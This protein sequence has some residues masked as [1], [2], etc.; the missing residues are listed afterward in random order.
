MPT[1][2]VES[3]GAAAAVAE[4][5][6]RAEAAA[7]LGAGI[8]YIRTT[9]VPADQTLLHVFEASSPE[10][11]GEAVAG[12]ALECD[13]IVEVVET[14]GDSETPRRRAG[15]TVPSARWERGSER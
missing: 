13:R 8:S 7:R 3:Y 9:I 5:R 10:A 15:D 6:A 11:L 2:I 1:Y 4:Q 12:A 14:S